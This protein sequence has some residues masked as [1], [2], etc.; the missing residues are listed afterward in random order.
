[1]PVPW[2]RSLAESGMK[3]VSEAF[4][5]IPL[6]G[7]LAAINTEEVERDETHYVLVPIP[8]DAASE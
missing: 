3:S 4:H 8:L 1:M 7:A 2:P 5:G 6:F